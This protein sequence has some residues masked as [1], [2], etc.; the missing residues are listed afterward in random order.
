LGRVQQGLRQL[1][2]QRILSSQF[3]EQRLLAGKLFQ[4][5]HDLWLRSGLHLYAG[6]LLRAGFQQ[7]QWLQLRRLR[8]FQQQQWLQLRSVRLFQ[9]QRWLLAREQLFQRL[10]LILS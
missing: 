5:R 1:I 2:E 10:V 7:Q 4:Q 3:F 8:L 9:Q 6:L